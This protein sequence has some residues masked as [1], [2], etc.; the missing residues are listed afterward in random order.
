MRALF[1]I[2]RLIMASR[3]GVMLRGALLGVVVLLAG[4]ALLGLSGWFITAA[5]AAGLVGAGAV[6]D[7][8]RPAAAVRMLALGRTA[9]RYGER[10]LTHDATLRALTDLRA[11]LL[12]HLSQAPHDRLVRLR[13]ALALNR[14]MADVDALDA[15]PLRFAL[16]I[17][18]ALV[19]HLVSFAALVLLVDLRVA[20]WVVATYVIAAGAI[21]VWAARTADKPSRRVERARQAFRARLIDLLRAR[22]DLAVYGRLGDQREAVLD[23]DRRRGAERARLDRTERFA[24]A[25]L[26]MTG[27]LVVAGAL[28]LGAW[29]VRAGVFQAPVAA[30]GVFMALAL[31]E[32]IAPLRRTAA[33]MGRMSDAARRVEHSLVPD[34]G[35]A[36]GQG[37]TTPA[38]GAPAIELERVCF[39]RGAAGAPV[40]NGF[41]LCLMPGQT[42]ALEGPSGRGKSTLL[43]I[44]AGLLTPQG[45][46]VR[47]LGHPVDAWSPKAL[48][49]HLALLPQRSALMSG[50]IRE[51]LSLACPDLPDSAAWEVL[52]AVCL[53]QTLRAKG[54]LDWRLGEAGAGLSGGEQRRLALARVLLRRP[55]VLLLDEPTE[56][57]DAET[58]MRVLAGLRGYLP[59]A[60]ILI[61]SHNAT[62]RAW[63]GATICV[64]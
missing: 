38:A 35:P 22:D 21:L 3:P 2:L 24:G 51:A 50:S 32:S 11:L 8:F 10:L 12:R 29:L 60:A 63:A 1:R 48:R 54:G 42:V 61:A 43:L 5:A 36:P 4:V 27:T 55:D 16:P 14:L 23:A 28:L 26:A 20:V 18:S 19:A 53:E 33:E 57:L 59:D 37:Q 6:F 17:L 40:L 56:G 47:V 62:E 15:I 45:G 52:R 41:S 7:V 44:L 58:A 64:G 49:R 25:L 31:A 46:T 34:A 30:L 13:G 9:A 39:S